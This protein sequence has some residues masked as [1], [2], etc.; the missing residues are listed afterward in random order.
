MAG[1]GNHGAL[2]AA[3]GA[4]LEHA[5]MQ[6]PFDVSGR[7]QQT[8][9]RY[10]ELL[11]RWNAT[12]NLTSVRDPLE[13]VTQHLA[14]A[15]SVVA[16]LRAKLPVRAGRSLLDVG[17]GAGLPGLVIAA[18]EPELQITCVDTVG[19]KIAFVRQAIGELGLAN[20]T[21]VHGR[22][23]QIRQPRVDVVCARAFASLVDLALWTRHLLLPDGV[24]MALKGR[25]PDEEIAALP[26]DVEVFHVEQIR[27]PGMAAERCIVW[28]RPA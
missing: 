26:T 21:A 16:P 5:C 12:Y 20:V 27:V 24:W 13:M 14:D 18:L 6:L 17:T 3:L 2:G 9:L 25:Q 10:V 11:A 23:E 28:M 1:D 8:L 4:A 15:L 22:V 19:K 7:Q